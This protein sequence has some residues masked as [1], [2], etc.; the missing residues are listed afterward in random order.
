MPDERTGTRPLENLIARLVKDGVL[1][2]HV[3]A[4][5]D[6]V[7]ELGN[8]ATHADVSKDFS[9][10]DAFRA[11]DALM[12][13][14]DWYFKKEQ[15][16]DIDRLRREVDADDASVQTYRDRSR[17]AEHK[18]HAATLWRQFGGAAGVLVAAVALGLADRWFGI[19]PP[20]PPAAQTALFTF[21]AMGVAWFANDAAMRG[22]VFNRRTP[23]WLM[24]AT[25]AALIVFLLLMSLFTIPAPAWPNLESRGLWLQDPIAKNMQLHPGKTVQDEFEGEGYDPLAIW[26]PWTVTA[27]R[28]ALLL[29]WLSMAAGVA[30][31]ADCFWWSIQEVHYDP[32]TPA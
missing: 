19:G 29:S 25:G 16:G 28:S 8:A 32:T 18:R 4:Y 24:A 7:R 31:L 22:D 27:V 20:W 1:D 12:V 13:V 2:L 3:K 11:L 26:E 10:A 5:V 14:L 15:I 30:A 21:L 23:R 17:Q 9:E 6:H